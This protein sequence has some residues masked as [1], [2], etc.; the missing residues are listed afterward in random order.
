MTRAGQSGPRKPTSF[1]LCQSPLPTR[2]YSGEACSSQRR[3]PC[4]AIRRRVGS[5]GLDIVEMH[6]RRRGRCCSTTPGTSRSVSHRRRD[7]YQRRE[8]SYL[9]ARCLA[10]AGGRL[11]HWR[12]QCERISD[13]SPQDATHEHRIS[14]YHIC[15]ASRG[16]RAAVPSTLSEQSI[17]PKPSSLPVKRTCCVARR[18]RTR[19]LTPKKAHWVVELTWHA[20]CSTRRRGTLS[21]V[22]LEKIS[23]ESDSLG[24]F[25][26]LEDV[27]DRLNRALRN[28]T[29]AGRYNVDYLH[30]VSV[31]D[32]L[33]FFP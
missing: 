4:M 30:V 11:H 25:H 21:A 5:A 18:M 13:H 19:G 31:A 17:W 3:K 26:E 7:V 27:S 1:A 12:S 23:Y 20:G 33:P 32:L 24:A 14:V 6:R 22:Q 16:L 8:P 9:S 2:A 15:A 10:R 29:P 28:A